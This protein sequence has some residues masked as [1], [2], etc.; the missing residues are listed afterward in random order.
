MAALTQQKYDM[1]NQIAAQAQEYYDLL[2]PEERREFV[3]GLAYEFGGKLN[4]ETLRDW[5][6]KLQR[7]TDKQT[8]RNVATV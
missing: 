1:R 7:A 8:A 6:G 5:L 3:S 4:V 2:T